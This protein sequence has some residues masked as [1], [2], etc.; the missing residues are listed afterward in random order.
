MN[1]ACS[2]P[3][4][5]QFTRK[6]CITGKCCQALS[7]RWDIFV[8]TAISEKM[9]LALYV[10]LYSIWTGA[11]STLYCMV[12]MLCCRSMEAPAPV[13]DGRGASEYFDSYGDLDVSDASWQRYWLLCC[14]LWNESCCCVTVNL[15]MC[16]IKYHGVKMC[17]GGKYSWR[18]LVSLTLQSH[19]LGGCANPTVQVEMHGQTEYLNKHVQ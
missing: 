4:L 11:C 10:S 13:V 15:S 18:W 5:L 7:L 16:L 6:W 3:Y 12:W 9:Y 2:M 8:C 14:V 1:I 19:W 17:V